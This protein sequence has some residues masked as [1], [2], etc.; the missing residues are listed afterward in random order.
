MSEGTFTDFVIVREDPAAVFLWKR[1]SNPVD[2]AQA[3]IDGLCE[4]LEQHDLAAGD[5]AR[6]AH[7]TTVGTNALIERRIGEWRS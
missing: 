1:P 2:P 5:V 7:G 4:A 3:I 6:L